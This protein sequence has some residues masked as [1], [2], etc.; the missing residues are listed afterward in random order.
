MNQLQKTS[1]RAARMLTESSFNV[2]IGPLIKSLG[3]KTIRGLVDEDSKLIVYK[4]IDGLAPLYIHYL[5]TRNSFDNS[6]S[7][8]NTATD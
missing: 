7:L 8:R 3:W 5:F 6:Y 1:K 2:P 4:C